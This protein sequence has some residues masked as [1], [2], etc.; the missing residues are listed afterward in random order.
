MSQI[1]NETFLTGTALTDTALWVLV[2]LPAVVGG[3]LT[4]SRLE[5]AAAAISLVTATALDTCGKRSGGPA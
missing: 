1:L 4:L 3:A 2:L 5:R